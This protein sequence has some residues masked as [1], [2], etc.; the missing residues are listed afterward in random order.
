MIARL[1]GLFLIVC[2]AFTLAEQRFVS[3]P[4]QTQLVELYTSEGCS[5]CPPADQWLSRY[6]NDKRLWTSVVPV[7]FHVDYW[8]DIGWPDRFADA[9]YSYRQR[10]HDR[11]GNVRQVYTPG[12]VVDGK[13]WRGWFRRLNPPAAPNVKPGILMLTTDQQQFSA[14]LDAETAG[15]NPLVIALLGANLKTD[16]KAGENRG[17]L[18]THDFV[19]LAMQYYQ[20][21][22]NQ[23]QGRLP[24]IAPEFNTE[25]LAIAAWVEQ[26]DTLKPIQAVGGWIDE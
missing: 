5:S 23:W 6:V 10:L 3:Q 26:G 21:E 9:A 4:Q 12:F 16:V 18:L 25:K 14:K 24:E 20:G 11:Q 19:V 17:E 13:E 7:A 8:D 2:S 1:I 15:D 22:G